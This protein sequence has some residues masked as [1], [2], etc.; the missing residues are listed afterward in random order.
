MIFWKN[1]PRN[2]FTIAFFLCILNL[3]SGCRVVGA[4]NTGDKFPYVSYTEIPGVTEEDAREMEALKSRYGSF[5]FGMVPG[6]D[7][8][9]E[10]GAIRGFSALF[11]EWLTGFFGIPF[12]PVLCEHDILL[13][14]LESGGINFSGALSAAELETAG[15]FSAGPITEQSF[16]FTRFSGSQ[17]LL[18]IVAARMP[19][20]AFLSGDDASSRVADLAY[21]D[22][23]SFFVD[24]YESAYNLLKEGRVDAFFDEG[25]A[26]AEFMAH[27]DIIAES[28]LPMI[29]MPV[30][31]S[32][33]NRELEPVIRL[34]QKALQNGGEHLFTGMNKLGQAEFRKSR[35]LLRLNETE[36][37]FIQEHPVIPIVAEYY[38]YPISFYN[39][40]EKEWQGIY[41]DVLNEISELTGLGFTV[42]NNENTDWPTLLAKLVSGEAAI[43]SELLPSKERQGAFLWPNTPL[44][45]D[46]YA[47]LSRSDTPNISINEVLETSIGLPRATAYAE[48]FRRWFPNHPRI[49]EYESSDE[50]F[51]A[52]DRG[53]VDVVVSSQRRLLALT[54]YSELTGYKA[55]L[56]FDVSAESFIG[57]NKN[58]GILCSIFD[59]AFQFVD[60]R[61]IAGQWVYKT[62]DYKAKLVRAQR[63][64]LIGAAVL[65]ICVVILISIL[66]SRKYNEGTRLEMLVQKRTSELKKLQHDLEMAFENAQAGSR[67]KSVFLANMSHEIRTPMNAIIG[68]TN[69]GKT[70]DDIERKDY[71]FSR[72]EDASL[73]LL[74]V[75]NDIL[76]MSKIEANK[77]AL[78]EAEF[79]FE[80]MLQSVVNVISMQIEEKDQKFKVYFD[81]K[82]P[83]NLF[84]DELRLSQVISNLVS[85]AVKFTPEGGSIRIGTYF[86]GEED[87]VCNI[88][89]TVTDSGIGISPS[90]QERLFQSFQQAESGSSR[91]YGGSGLGLMISKSIVEMMGGGIWVESEQ[92]KGSTFSF[93]VRVKRGE[94]R[95]KKLLNRGVNWGNVRI[96]SVDDDPDTQAF[97]KKIL[98]E[99]GVSIDASSSGEE[100]LELI[101]R[102]GTYDIYL[103]DWK[104]PGMDGISLA[105]RLKEKERDPGDVSV[106]LFSAASLSHVE[107]EAK[108]AGVDRFMSKPLFPS[109]I[110]GI[111]DDCLGVEYEQAGEGDI[112]EIPLYSERH[113]LLAEDVDINCEIVMALLEPTQIKIDWAQNGAAAVNMFAEGYEKYDMIFMDLQMPEM[114]GYTATRTI[115]A[116]DIPKAKTIPI[117][118]MTANVFQDDVENCLNAGMNSHIGKPLDL[119]EVLSMLRTYLPG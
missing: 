29:R 95:E 85:N 36:R 57:F 94:E 65:S 56:V 54:N 55:N 64:W 51:R 87:G 53:E 102:N 109:V 71:C 40:Y 101:A 18:D 24:D 98:G 26:E 25:R 47:L 21:Y 72:I 116:M 52:L 49:T 110:R 58:E 119:E 13:A 62:Y 4:D 113:I 3:S 20:Y 75:I 111:I 1:L 39:S 63:P 86:L 83:E 12:I 60:V 32:T 84:G 82:I 69:I 41:F 93:S 7:A 90:Q 42:V 8:Y 2:I 11:C 74:G 9:E 16:R 48:Q 61:S 44:L 37:Q 112:S 38:N 6:V 99:Y 33:G 106:V 23:E 104:L 105:A 97:L 81:R 100:A 67:A 78:S 59:S 88:Q 80:K 79:K 15:Y 14:G 35:L 76:D 108:M 115:R 77:F 30:S 5:T 50:S 22:F 118:A 34:V 10:D 70:S 66:F 46:Y 92:G 45:V 68:M 96:L 27:E 114:D 103:V 73:H 89:I 91:R 31:M 19:R 28:F 17:P 43:V 117:I 107:L